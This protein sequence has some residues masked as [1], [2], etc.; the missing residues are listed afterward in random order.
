MIPFS[1]YISQPIENGK[2]WSKIS[3]FSLKDNK[4]WIALSQNISFVPRIIFLLFFFLWSSTALLK[5]W[6]TAMD[7]NFRWEHWLKMEVLK[8]FF[9]FFSSCF[10]RSSPWPT[11]DMKLWG[12][13]VG[14]GHW[15]LNALFTFYDVLSFPINFWSWVSC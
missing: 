1:S 9:W 14:S 13:V 15:H 5:N 2:W 10:S 7:S 3:Y 6:P 8:R 12:L 4:A 11:G